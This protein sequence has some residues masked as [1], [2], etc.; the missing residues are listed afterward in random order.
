MFKVGDKVV[1]D[2]NSEEWKKNL[3]FDWAEEMEQ[4]QPLVISK[5]RESWSGNGK[6]VLSFSNSIYSA[7]ESWVKL[8]E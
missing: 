7:E 5:I 2:N 4:E 1:V 8:A 6:T 3:G